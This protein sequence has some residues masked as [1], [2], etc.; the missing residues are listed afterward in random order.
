DQTQKKALLTWDTF[1]VGAK[2]DL[3]FNQRGNR[4]WV[5]LNRV[6]DPSLAPSRILGS[7]KGDGSIYVI[8]QNGIIFGGTSQVNVGTLV[9]S[10]FSLSNE[11]FF[12]GINNPLISTDSS[13]N[14]MIIKPQFGYLGQRQPN[15]FVSINDPSQ[16]PGAVIG[17]PP[18]DVVVEAGADIA[19]AT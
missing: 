14:T 6:L 3:T 16:V 7:I 8:N 15:Q 2:T 9:A 17:A 10:S 12:A 13:G 5:A 11:Q 18:G 19:T 4:D 1:N